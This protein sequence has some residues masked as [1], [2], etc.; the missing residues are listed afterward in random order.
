[1]VA[2]QFGF[3]FWTSMIE[4]VMVEGDSWER[5]ACLNETKAIEQLKAVSLPRTGRHLL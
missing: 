3:T 4:V 2:V 5:Q 1:M